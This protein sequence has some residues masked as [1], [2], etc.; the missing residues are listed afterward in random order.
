VRSAKAKGAR[1]SSPPVVVLP[2]RRLHSLTYLQR[3]PVSG[4][5]IDRSFVRDMGSGGTELRDRAATV[6]LAKSLG[7]TVVAEGI[8]DRETAD[9]L[10]EFGCDHAQGY[11]FARPAPAAEPGRHLTAGN[12]IF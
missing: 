7:L 10:R 8:E 1:T 2:A 9:A 3:F 12:L 6:Q 5:K 4:I 11:F